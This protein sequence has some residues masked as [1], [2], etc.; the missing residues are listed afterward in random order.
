I[1]PT[2]PARRSKR[3]TAPALNT[4]LPF[5][6]NVIG[7]MDYTPLALSPST[8]PRK[9]TLGHELALTVLFESGIVHLV[10]KPSAI[11]QLPFAT[12]VLLKYL[13]SR[14]DQTKFLLGWPGKDVIIARQ[15]KA[16]W[17]VAGINGEGKEK[18]RKLDLRSLGTGLFE[19]EYHKDDLAIGKLTTEFI[20]VQ[21]VTPID[22]VLP[23]YGGFLLKIRKP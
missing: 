10:E 13:P 17:Y 20:K 12:K 14:W 18:K 8:H 6:R 3:P 4:I 5:T 16:L 2:A 11:N 7:P 1:A 19:I 21:S 22:I 15:S 23:P 9:T